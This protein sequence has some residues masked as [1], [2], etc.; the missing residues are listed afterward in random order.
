MTKGALVLVYVSSPIKSLVGAFKVDQVV[1]KPLRELWKLVC[2]RAAV[3]RDEFDG[4]FEGASTG[5]GIFFNEVW[6]L[7]RPIELRDL[8]EMQGFRPPQGFRYATASELA[9][10]QLAELVEDTDAL[11]QTTYLDREG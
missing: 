10:P 5:V 8:R 7:H 1:E 11:V 3:T 2:G 6:R 9:S 4:Y